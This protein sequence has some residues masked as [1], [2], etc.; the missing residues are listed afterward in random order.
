MDAPSVSSNV[1]QSPIGLP[2]AS[3]STVATPTMGKGRSG[4]PLRAPTVA[5]ITG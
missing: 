2:A 4:L 3:A 1:Y 5:R